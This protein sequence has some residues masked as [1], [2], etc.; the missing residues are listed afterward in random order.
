MVPDNGLKHVAD[1]ST[2]RIKTWLTSPAPAM[3]EL[4]G[5]LGDDFVTLTNV[6]RDDSRDREREPT[7]ASAPPGLVH[8]T[9]IAGQDC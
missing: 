6:V 2:Q 7:S 3:G 4:L 8:A 5:G 9:E 1:A